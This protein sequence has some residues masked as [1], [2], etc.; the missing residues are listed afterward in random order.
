MSET[1]TARPRPPTQAGTGRRLL[2]LLIALAGWALFL[3]W[4]WLVLGR[5]DPQEVR[6]TGIFILA[7][8]VLCVVMTGLWAAHNV[9]IFKRR[10]PRKRVRDVTYD[11]SRDRLGR[12]VSFGGPLE[13]MEIAPI[14]H[15]RLEHE[16]KVYRTAASV[17]A[18]MGNGSA[19]FRQKERSR[20]AR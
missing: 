1:R 15:I 14:V 20:D 13:Q 4:W 7:T 17:Q 11:F 8:L 18:S 12:V 2:H 3:W 5:T 10:G 9:A 16:G 6:F 19:I